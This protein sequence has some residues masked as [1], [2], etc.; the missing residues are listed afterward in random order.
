MSIQDWSIYPNFRKDEFSCKCGCGTN[1]MQPAFMAKLQAL[2]YA[3]GKPMVITSGYR[4]SAHPVEAKKQVPG[5]G[6]HSQGI[7]SDIGVSGADAQAL[8]RLALEAGFAGI[9]IQQKGHGRYIHLD[10]REHPA[11]WSY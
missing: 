7:A 9:G 3:Y 10:I 5:T 4:C 2:R 6:T 11:L 8:L 1:E